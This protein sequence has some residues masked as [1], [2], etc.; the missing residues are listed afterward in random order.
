MS[1]TAGSPTVPPGD[2]RHR[3]GGATDSADVPWAGRQLS[4]TGFEADTGEADPALLDALATPGDDVALM[5]AVEAARFVVP[6]VTEPTEVDT[7]GEHAVDKQVDLSAVTPR[8]T[9]RA[10]GPAGVLRDRGARRVGPRGPTRPRHSGEGR[11]GRR[12]RGL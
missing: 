1:G 2:D 9:R 3:P 4:P 10:P 6:I 5:R 11:P 7:S 12:R 8:R